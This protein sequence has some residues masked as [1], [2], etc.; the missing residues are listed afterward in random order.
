[1]NAPQVERHQGER[2]VPANLLLLRAVAR[3]G[4]EELLSVAP[5]PIEQWA[6][7]A[8]QQQGGGPSVQRLKWRDLV[9]WL[10]TVHA[11]AGEA[12]ASIESTASL[13][14]GLIACVAVF[15]SVVSVQWIRRP[16]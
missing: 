13:N 11:A 9:R 8:L 7:L 1:M 10:R 15:G 12:A 5:H 3:Q 6:I 14:K 16:T 2:P 4:A